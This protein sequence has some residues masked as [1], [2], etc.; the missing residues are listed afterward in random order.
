MENHPK[1]RLDFAYPAGDML[2]LDFLAFLSTIFLAIQSEELGLKIPSTMSTIVQ[3]A[4]Q[5]F[6]ATFTF[7]IVSVNV[8]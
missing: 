2:S 4:I 1:S 7:R 5:Y 8:V 6:L 3:D